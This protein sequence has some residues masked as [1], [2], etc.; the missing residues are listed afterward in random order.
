MADTV[1]SVLIK[2]PGEGTSAKTLTV[3]EVSII[4]PAFN[5]GKF[6]ETS[7]AHVAKALSGVSDHYELILV[8]DGSAD[9]TYERIKNIAA[10][11]S[12][13]RVIRNG[14]NSGKGASVKRAAAIATGRSVIVIDSDMEID[15]KMIQSYLT[16]LKDHDICIASKRLPQ[17]V[18]NAP[19]ARK[20]LSTAFNK[21]VRVMTG[22]RFSDTQTGLKAANGECFKKICNVLSV[23]RY[24]YD[25]EFLAV[26]GLMNLRVAELPVRHR[27]NL[28][29]QRKGSD[30]HG[31]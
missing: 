20:F 24:A 31:R 28:W 5:E 16:A 4:M 13:V 12:K 26:A 11:N 8:D 22:V 15:P 27:T 25:V 1:Q 14:R 9:D 30:V 19:I 2:K 10:K 3:P 21:I 18:Y 23:K 29:L 7:V 6:I 17:S